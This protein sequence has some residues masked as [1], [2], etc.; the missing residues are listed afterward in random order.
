MFFTVKLLNDNLYLSKIQWKKI[1][2]AMSIMTIALYVIAVVCSLTGSDYFIFFYQNAQMDRIEEFLEKY[3]LSNIINSLFLT[4]EFAIVLAFTLNRPPKWYY[5]LSFLILPLIPH[6]IFGRLPDAYYTLFPF[7]FYLVIPAI[8]QIIDNHKSEY[9]QRFSFKKY[10]KCLLRV[11]IATTITLILQAMILVIKSGFFNGQNNIQ[12][13]SK[14]FIYA[15]EY[16]IALA[17]ILYTIGLFMNREKGDSKLWVTIHNHG[18]SS[19]VSKKQSLKS[20]TKK[21]LTKTQKS[22]IRR[23]LFKV[24]LTQIGAFLLVMVLPFLLG[25]V[26]EFLVMYTAFCV[27]RYI[28]GFNYSLHYKKEAMCVTVGVIV[29]GILSLAVPFFYVLM[30]IAILIGAGL[31]IILHLSYKYKGVWLFSKVARPDKYAVLYVFFEGDL[32]EH[33]VKKMCR[34]KG[35]TNE[36]TELIEEYVEGHKISYIAY[37]H[38]YSQRMIIYKLDEAIEK[39]IK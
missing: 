28:L 35:L 12:N 22:K 10:L 7:A 3:N 6:Y 27:A 9:I 16:D 17:I 19:Q 33:H 5:V 32:S 34:Y 2:L 15:I 24:Y 1:F 38:N 14:A 20:S 26:F 13:L 29:F 30:I 36:E 18:G 4:F 25:K 21:N 39:L 11:L 37:K 8:Q 23:L 31:A